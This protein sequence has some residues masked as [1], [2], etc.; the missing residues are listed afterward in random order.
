MELCIENIFAL[1][2]EAKGRIE[3]LWETFQDR[4]VVELRLAGAATIDE[5]N[6]VLWEYLPKFNARFGVPAREDGSAYR[7]PDANLL[8]KGT[9]CFKYERTV[10]RDNTIRFDNHVIQ[11]LPGSD[12]LSYTHAKVEVQERLDGSIVVRYQGRTIA[13]REAPPSPVTLRARKAE[14][15]EPTCPG[16]ASPDSVGIPM[17][18][19]LV[20]GV[21]TDGVGLVGC[22]IG[23]QVGGAAGCGGDQE[24]IKSQQG[25]KRDSYR[26]PANHPWR[27]FSL[28]KSLNT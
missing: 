28:T 15:W 3:R 20:V 4:L 22:G 19:G 27:K 5:A 24:R 23:A 9:L 6:R 25:D 16:D 26:P 2:P 10:A 8:L 21:S 17:R 13:S 12:R 1:S 11:L 7:K 14:R 18:R